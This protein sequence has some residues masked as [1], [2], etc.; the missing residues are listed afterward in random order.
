MPFL[1]ILTGIGAERLR[2]RRVRARTVL[3]GAA[4]GYTLCLTLVSQSQFV[5]E[6]RYRAAEYLRETYGDENITYTHYARSNAMP[7]GTALGQAALGSV[8]VLHETSYG[9]YSDAYFTTPFGP[10][11]CCSEVYHC[12]LYECLMT[13]ELLYGASAYVLDARVAAPEVFPERI[14]FK[15]FFGT[16]ETMLGD[17]LVFVRR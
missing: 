12:N 9:R 17:V 15:R 16:Y 14:L 4:F 8:L 11:E 10:P 6:T 5:F 3:L 13:Q 1:A 7:P 2:E